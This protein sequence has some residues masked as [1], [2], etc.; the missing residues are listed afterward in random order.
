MQRAGIYDLSSPNYSIIN[1]SIQELY[2]C[3]A[4]VVVLV[5]IE[6]SCIALVTIPAGH[7][8]LV[9]PVSLSDHRPLTFW[10]CP[11]DTGFC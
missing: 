2:D 5:K 7:I 6:F 11:H 3:L 10:S 8:L 4:N 1:L 9:P